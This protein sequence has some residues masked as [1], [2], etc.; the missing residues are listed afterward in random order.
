MQIFDIS[1]ELFSSCVYPGDPTPKR[2]M[3]SEIEKGGVCNLTALS[4]CAHNGTHI[5][6]PY[7]FFENGSGVDQIPLE[8]TVGYATV[9]SF[10]GDIL[11]EDA[12]RLLAEAKAQNAEAAKRILIKGKATLTLA[13][14]ELFSREG[15]LLFGNESQ[16]VGPEEAPMA[17]HKELLSHEIALLEGVRLSSVSDG[18]YFL[19]AAPINLGGADGA[20]TRAILIKDIKE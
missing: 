9:K 17:V 6:A 13:A 16:T 3:L 10:S 7:H 2:E 5:D 8:S 4:L 18:V 12:A 20:P 19:F 15:V 1:Q 14:A 11:K